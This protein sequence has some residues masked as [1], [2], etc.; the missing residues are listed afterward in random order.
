MQ[1]TTHHCECI[2]LFILLRRIYTG[3]IDGTDKDHWYIIHGVQYAYNGQ[4]FVRE[5]DDTSF[6][7]EISG[8]NIRELNQPVFVIDREGEEDSYDEDEQ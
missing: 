6:P 1:K 3:A 8:F 7:L 2:P 5:S 4:V